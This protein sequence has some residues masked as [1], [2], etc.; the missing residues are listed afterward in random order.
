M[1]DSGSVVSVWKYMNSPQPRGVPSFRAASGYATATLAPSKGRLMRCTVDGLRPT[2]SASR[3]SHCT[4]SSVEPSKV[5]PLISSAHNDAAKRA[6]L[7]AIVMLTFSRCSVAATRLF[8]SGRSFQRG[9]F[10]CFE[11]QSSLLP[12]P[13]R[14]VEHSPLLR[15]MPLHAGVAAVAVAT[16]EEVVVTEGVGSPV[17][18][19]AGSAAAGSVAAGLVV[20][21]SAVV[22]S[23]ASAAGLA[24]SVQLR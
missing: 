3:T 8:L 19:L 4:A 17:V 23:V 12:S 13:P 24:V 22:Q 1:A 5:T 10:P 14:S 11:K 16:E 2:T 15:L 6:P 7:L 18:M 21:V 20:A 9:D